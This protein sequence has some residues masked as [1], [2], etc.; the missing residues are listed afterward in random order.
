MTA[1]AIEISRS[2]LVDTADQRVLMD[3]ISWDD[4]EALLRM[5]GDRSVPR[6]VYLDGALELMTTSEDHERIKS[7]LAA[8]LQAYMLHIGMEFSSYGHWTLKRRAE[9][10]GIEADD[11][12]RIGLDQTRGR[13]PDLALEVIWT[14]GGLDKL[15]AYRRL[16]VREVWM[17]QHDEIT[18][19]ALGPTGYVRHE[20]SSLVPDID[21]VEL[22]DH[23]HEPVQSAAIRAYTEA[24]RAR[25][26]IGPTG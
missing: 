7:V 23:V 11:C 4:Y 8:L 2:E 1:M 9:R 17:W 19:H 12:Y 15:E 14:H 25:R 20:R 24:L 18:V 16:G 26:A 13:M 22:A 3:G 21:L 10:S 6:I 5:R